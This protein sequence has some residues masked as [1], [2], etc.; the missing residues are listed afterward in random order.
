MDET[1]SLVKARSDL[2][3]LSN[4]QRIRSE[5]RSFPLLSRNHTLV[6]RRISQLGESSSDSQSEFSFEPDQQQVEATF[7]HVELFAEKY[8]IIEKL[9]EGSNGVVHRCLKRRSGQ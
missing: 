4:I 6:Q 3:R 7:E 9:G 5:L 2:P 8:E 1:P